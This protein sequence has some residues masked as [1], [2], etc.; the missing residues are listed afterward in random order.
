M[1]VEII[2]ESNIF[3]DMHADF[4]LNGCNK[5]KNFN[6]K[7]LV[8][9]KDTLEELLFG[10]D[11]VINLGDNSGKYSEDIYESVMSNSENDSYISILGN[12]DVNK[13]NIQE[14]NIQETSKSNIEKFYEKKLNDVSLKKIIKNKYGLFGKAHKEFETVNVDGRESNFRIY[15]KTLN[16]DEGKIG[17]VFRHFPFDFERAKEKRI[18]YDFIKEEKLSALYFVAGHW[19]HQNYVSTKSNQ[20]KF[21]HSDE[22]IP[23]TSIVLPPF[24]IGHA[25]KNV[26][27]EPKFRPYNDICFYASVYHM[28]ILEDGSLLLNQR[29]YKNKSVKENNCQELKLDPSEN[30]TSKNYI[31]WGEL[32]G[33]S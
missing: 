31:E 20:K 4:Y 17:L 8:I 3:S 29:Y 5:N 22:K 1:G 12:H 15:A 21:E 11:A 18:A 30:K 14:I 2:F 25:D 27:G 24:T 26:I 6:K 9:L 10:T 16:V 13:L 28:R 33:I 7:S 32:I 23:I 19:H